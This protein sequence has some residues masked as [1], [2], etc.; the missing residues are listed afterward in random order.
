MRRRTAL[1]SISV[2]AAG[3]ALFPSCSESLILTQL[4]E[5]DLAFNAAQGTWL[6]AIS[7]AILPMGD[8]SITTLESLP[9]FVAQHFNVLSPIE[10]LTTFVNGYNLCTEEMKGIYESDTKELTSAQIISYFTDQLA[11]PET[12]V[13][14]MDEVSKLNMEA[15][16]LLSLIHISEP[17]RPY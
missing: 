1:K 6:E 14:P 13:A 4:P 2:I 10:D 3:A 15:K 9:A 5:E 7:E 17:T 8:K 16:K 11:E 12:P